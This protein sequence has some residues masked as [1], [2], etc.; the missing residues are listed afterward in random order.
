MKRLFYRLSRNRS[1]VK[2]LSL[3]VFVSFGFALAPAA[4]AWGVPGGG[5]G[6][7]FSTNVV[8]DCTWTEGISDL[9]GGIYTIQQT[10]RCA[11]KGT[12]ATGQTHDCTLS[13]EYDLGTPPQCVPQG[14]N[15]VVN[16]SAQCR[17]FDAAT[18]TANVT[19]TLMCP[20]VTLP[21]GSLGL[22][23]EVGLGS[24]QGNSA[25]AFNSRDCSVFGGPTALLLS[26][27]LV[28][29]DSTC[30]Q[31]LLDTS[32]TN[33][34]ACHADQGPVGLNGEVICKENGSA[35]GTNTG[36]TNKAND[37]IVTCSFNDPWQATCNPNK[38]NGVVK[39]TWIGTA[40]ELNG[41]GVDPTAI[42]QN[43]VTLNDVPAKK[44][45]LKNG[46][47]ECTFP[48]CGGDG[49]TFIA[50]NAVATMLARFGT[51]NQEVSCSSN[52]IIR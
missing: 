25:G 42:V 31:L 14:Q 4:Y 21:N 52:V 20:T 24:K 10:G 43:S 49:K 45:Q 29:K 8:A 3:L 41:L 16:I 27:R 9:T 35:T 36:F 18:G 30:S 28:F 12:I 44:C 34:R 6:G 22:I 17:D 13:M 5:S 38:D 15:F 32:Q 47:L 33:G 46:T 37:P 26:H 51:N 11:F 1:F 19:G 48:S 40:A 39:G 50:P 7:W 23:E 2:L